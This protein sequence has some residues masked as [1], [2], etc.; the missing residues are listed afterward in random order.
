MLRSYLNV[1]LPVCVERR[2]VRAHHWP[3]LRR[4]SPTRHGAAISQDW[5]TRE[6]TGTLH[7]PLPTACSRLTGA[8]QRQ[9]QKPGCHRG[10]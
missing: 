1:Q 9:R 4:S 2:A 8:Q 3:G 5:L 6:G 10:R 7:N